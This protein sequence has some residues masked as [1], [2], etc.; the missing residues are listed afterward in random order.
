MSDLAKIAA[1]QKPAKR[2]SK[3]EP[4]LEDLRK[5][6]NDGYSL[7]QMKTFLAEIGVIVSRQSIYDFL[8]RRESVAAKAASRAALAVDGNATNPVAPATENQAGKP[9]V[10]NKTTTQSQL[11]AITRGQIDPNQFL[12]E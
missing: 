9:S 5:L 10:I 3:L 12:D 11:K 6:Q 1:S 4:Y 7:E 8:K 2:R